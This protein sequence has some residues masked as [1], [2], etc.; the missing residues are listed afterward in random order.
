MPHLRINLLEV[1]P[2]CEAFAPLVPIPPDD[3]VKAIAEFALSPSPPSKRHDVGN[4]YQLT[5]SRTA[6]RIFFMILLYLTCYIR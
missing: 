1:D 5:G 3:N 4:S 2:S 6:T